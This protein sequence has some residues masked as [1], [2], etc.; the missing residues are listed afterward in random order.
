MNAA[1]TVTATFTLAS[2]TLTVAPGGA[3]TGAVTSTPAGISCGSDCSEP[4]AFGTVVTLTA[5]ANAGSGF[6]GWSGACTGTGT[7]VV[8]MNAATS[9]TATFNTIGALGHGPTPDA[10]LY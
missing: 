5:A 3:G 6:A 10:V 4:Y 1:Q 7:C 8:T 2:F 9:V